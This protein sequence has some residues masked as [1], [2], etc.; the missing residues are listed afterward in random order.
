MSSP[1]P[2]SRR[3]LAI[4]SAAGFTLAAATA[5]VPAFAQS[6]PAAGPEPAES[7]VTIGIDPSYQ[8]PEWE[9]WGT[10]LVWMSNATGGY[11]EEIR[12]RL[13]DMVFGDDGLNLNIARYNVGGGNAPNISSDYMKDGADMPG[14][15]AAPEGTTHEDKDWWD[16]ENPEHWNWD[17]DADQRWWVD[18][19]KD[20]VDHWE[21]FS[22]SPPYF[23]TV[24]GYVSGGFDSNADQIRTDTLDGFAIYMTEVMERIED[25]HGIEFDTVN[26]LNE[27]NTNYWG[28]TLGPDGVQPVGGRQE[29]AHAGPEL[30]QQVLLALAEE[31]RDADTEAVISAMDETNPGT[32]TA[33]W[34]A[35]S[36]EARAVVDQMNVHTYGTGQRTSVRDLAKAAEKTLWMSEVEGSFH[37]PTDYETMATGLGIADRIVDDIRELEPSAWV[38][39]QPIED[40]IPQQE[41]GGNWG[42]IHIPFDCTDEDTLETCPI[43]TNTKFDTIR[44]FTHYI[45]PGD[46][47]VQVDD[48]DSAAAVSGEGDDATLV[49]V[50]S[51]AGARE[52]TIDL[53]DFGSVECDA[54]VTPVVSSADGALVEGE[55]VAVDGT[56]ATLT[57]PG[58]SVTTFLIEG[59]SGAAEDAAM[60]QPDHVYRFSG[61][62][63]GKSI[64]PNADA[65]GIVQRS[66]D[67]S[68]LEQLW[69]VDQVTEGDTNRERY[70][71]VNADNGMRLAVGEDDLAVLQDAEGDPDHAA[72][73]YASTTGDGTYVLVNSGT[74]RVLDVWGQSTEDGAPVQTYTPTSGGNQRWATFDE[75]VL[76]LETVETYT[77]PGLVPDLPDTVPAV[78]PDGV[79][80]ELPVV[81]DMPDEWRW[82]KPRNVNVFGEAV[83]ALGNT[84]KAHAK[85]SVDTFTGTET[86]EAATYRGGVPELPETVSAVGKR[87][88]VVQ[89]P[90]L[91]QEAPE[92]AFD[93]LGEVLL[94][95]TAELI[96]GSPVD[97]EVAVTVTEAIEANAA[98]EEGVVTEATFTEGGYSTERLRNGD[99]TDKAWSNWVSGDKRTE[100]TI[101]FTLPKEHDLTRVVAYFYRDASS[102][103]FADELQVQY[104]AEDGTWVDAGD[105]VEVGTEG[106]PIVEVGVDART[107]AV[108]LHMTVGEAGW[109]TMS[110]IE[111]F[112]K[113]PDV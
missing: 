26:P 46:R 79:R 25:E 2:R 94:G 76:G 32:F 36:A 40:S 45:E 19:I 35:Y 107:T 50:H 87:G 34:N 90:V 18:Q 78:R 71:I 4:A 86:A 77:V 7:S 27:P 84:F 49:Y 65:T 42:S 22:N 89:L 53:S 58:R 60:F 108:R 15:W 64:A 95:G 63:S 54:T 5:A 99:L 10:S 62:A 66:E 56:S 75:T 57:V 67:V 24:S 101:T 72:Q 37:S 83:D 29:G 14:F 13:V 59:V 68:S 1:R 80:G 30:Q 73:W 92:G 111:V 81:W 17:A 21:A 8:H 16:P 74:G 11:P 102:N 98:L 33:N 12:E 91:W 104:L 41:G 112:A 97:A 103:T 51:N 28:T 52:V 55:S 61:F 82:K 105:A 38:F 110:E 109:I 96:D 85:V 69:Y 39:W 44:N 43:Q 3:A 31:L 20:D 23:Q 106:S 70:Q 100:D 88:T 93:E 6:D 47:F 113:A 48:A 9:G